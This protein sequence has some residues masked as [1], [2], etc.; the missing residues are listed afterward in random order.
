MSRTFPENIGKVVE[1]VSGFGEYEGEGYCWN[2]R[3][4]TNLASIGTIDGMTH[5][6]KEGFIADI[7]LRPISGVSVEDEILDKVNA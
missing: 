3:C 7:A 2:I 1:V 4:V 6:V 5:Y